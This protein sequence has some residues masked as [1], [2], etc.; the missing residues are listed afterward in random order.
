VLA[1][2][3]TDE[4]RATVADQEL[5]GAVFNGVGW[6]PLARLTVNAV[7]DANPQL[8]VDAQG[9]FVQTWFQDGALLTASA[10]DLADAVA[11]G[12]MEGTSAAADYR[13]LTGPNGELAAVWQSVGEAGQVDPAVLHYDRFQARWSEAAR[14]LSNSNRMERSFAG[15][16]GEDGTLHLAYDSVQVG[17]DAEGRPLLGQ[18]DLCALAYQPTVDLAIRDA[19]IL[20]DPEA[21]SAGEPATVSVVV[22]NLGTLA[23]TNVLVAI[24][25]GLPQAGGVA[26]GGTNLVAAALDGGATATV[27]VA[28]TVPYSVVSRTLVAVVD[29]GELVPDANRSNNSATRSVLQ[30]NL[31][32]DAMHSQVAAGTERAV[33]A[34]IA[35]VGGVAVSN[36]VTVVFREGA[37]T[38]AVIGACSVFPVEPGSQYEAALVWDAATVAS[39]S[40]FTTVWATVDEQELIDDASRADN[41]GST[42]VMTA[43]DGDDDGLPDGQELQLGTAPG[44]EDSDGDGIKDGDEV[45]LHDT[46]PLLVDTDGDG[47]SD[48][49]EVR[50]GTVPQDRESLLRILGVGANAAGGGG[51][52]VLTFQSVAGKRYVVRRVAAL[53]GEWETVG[54][55]FEA[56]GDTVEIPVGVAEGSAAAFYCIQLVE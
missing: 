20:L 23:A 41:V 19:M 38:G 32:V 13:L 33:Y 46:D 40:A 7:Q 8:A 21:P 52:V 4:D 56:T 50:A 25:D 17:A 37:S 18:V 16:F 54:E 44:N 11:A 26:I 14:L 27:S 35:N 45:L 28:W 1:C 30:A 2:L 6:S 43:L 51:P 12:G 53:G 3:D 15:A 5:Y 24:Y 29:P 55:P 42:V 9:G 31:A 39:T 49:D 48:G 22:A 47:M 10:A 34:R 36:T